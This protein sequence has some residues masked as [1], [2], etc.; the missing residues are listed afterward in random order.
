MN[1]F[2]ESILNV[3]VADPDDARRRRV[4]NI[5]LLGTLTATILG[6]IGIIIGSRSAG[7][8]A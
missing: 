8:L 5:L 2:L 4:L 6:V 7:E 3:P 1:R